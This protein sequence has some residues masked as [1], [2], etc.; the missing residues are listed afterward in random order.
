MRCRNTVKTTDGNSLVWCGVQN[1]QKESYAELITPSGT[2]NPLT[3]EA[4]GA[5]QYVLENSDLSILVDF[6]AGTVSYGGTTYTIVSVDK[7][8]QK[9]SFINGSNIGTIAVKDDIVYTDAYVDAQDGVKSDLIQRLSLLQGELWFNNSA[10]L[11]LFFQK[12]NKAL[13]DSRVMSTIMETPDVVEII[14][15]DSYVNAKT[16][17][18]IVSFSVTTRFTSEEMKVKLEYPL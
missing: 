12:T 16:K 17:E 3:I 11:P 18:Y 2:S 5:N 8:N 10:G 15:F 6:G 9:L 13:L 4:H 14:S 7:G 1:V